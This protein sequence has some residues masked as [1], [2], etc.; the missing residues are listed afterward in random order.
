VP[1][2][3]APPASSTAPG[4]ASAAPRG[5]A[6][7][8]GPAAPRGPIEK[9]DFH[10]HLSSGGEKR[11]LE[12]MR[13][14]SIRHAVNLSGGHPLGGLRRQLAAAAAHPGRFT[15]FASLAY[16]QAETAGYGER[17]A[18]AL[19]I[20]HQLGAR[21]LKIAKALGL[22]LPGP[23]GR[24]LPVDDPGLD[25]VFEAAGELGMPV[26]IHSGD[27]RAFWLPVDA[28]NERRAELEAHPGWSLHGRKVPSFAQLLDQLERRVARHPKTRFVSVH[29]GNAAEDPDRV[30][31]ALRRYPNLFIDT[32]ARVPEMG[33]HPRERLRAFFHEFQDRILFG[34]DLGVGPAPEPLFLGSSGSEPPTAEEERRFFASTWRYFETDDRAFPHPTPIQGDWTIDGLGLDRG[35]LEKVYARN[36]ERLLGLER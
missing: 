8:S 27:P 11:L 30:A 15:V 18:Q 32:A 10:V 14:Q 20:S 6:A 13:G 3:L 31:A 33:R 22:G 2:D 17:M 1:P 7:P 19:R 5:N 4:P 28:K 35:I 9:V 36:A 12:I 26:A 29:F 34:T 25:P 23:D 24:L 16:E 21:G